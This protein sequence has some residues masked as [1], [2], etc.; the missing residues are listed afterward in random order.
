ME[1]MVLMESHLAR[2]YPKNLKWNFISRLKWAK[3]LY[4]KQQFK[5]VKALNIKIIDEIFEADI[6]VDCLF[7]TGLNKPLDEKI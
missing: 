4:G 1:T 3:I 7:G 6:I 5:R 2:L